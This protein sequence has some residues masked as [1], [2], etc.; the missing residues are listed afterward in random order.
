MSFLS[1]MKAQKAL[2]AH[3][4]GRTEEAYAAYT[5]LFD[6]GEME[7]PRYLLPYSI[8]LL[9]RG[10]YEKAKTVLKKAEKA[11]GGLSQDQRCQLLTNYAVASWKLGRTDYA[12][13]LLQE[14]YRKGKNGAIYTTL[15]Y[16]LIEKGDFAETLAFNQEAV[17]YDD[18][19]PVA[20]DNLAQTYYRLGNDREEARKWFEKALAFKPEAIDTNYFLA[21]YDI[22]EGQYDRAREKLE[23]AKN[24]RLSPLNYATPERIDEALRSIPQA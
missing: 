16:L 24:G 4:K 3:S 20:L 8:L 14:V 18:E 7:S 10:E 12:V 11:P 17:D 19:D 5:E 13:E 6:K 9:R 15:G 22:E 23:I 21:L 1:G 2:I